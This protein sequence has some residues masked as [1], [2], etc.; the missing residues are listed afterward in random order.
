MT[1]LITQERL[2]AL[3]HLSRWRGWTVRPYSVGEHTAIGA[4][5]MRR[6]DL[7][8]EII[9]SWWLHDMHETEIGGDIPR[10]DKRVIVNDAYRDM[11]ADF[12]HRIGIEAGLPEGVW[13]CHYVVT[14]M[15]QMMLEVENDLIT[16]RRDLSLSKPDYESRMVKMIRDLIHDATFSTFD[17]VR[18]EWRE[19]WV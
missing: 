17:S 19:V 1:K 3:C 8:R 18:R 13:N 10:P 2:R 4:N 14:G 11:V 15:D 6:M 7:N 5:V 12:D 16:T 9:K